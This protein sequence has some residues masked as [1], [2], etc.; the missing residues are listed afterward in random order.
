MKKSLVSVLV[1]VTSYGFGQEI[2][3]TCFDKDNN[4]VEKSKSEYCVV[5]KQIDIPVGVTEIAPR[6]IYVDTL[7]GFYTS[8]NA[9]KFIEVY[10]DEGLLH[11]PSI[12]YYP[13]RHVLPK[14]DEAER[15]S[16]SNF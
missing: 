14:C 13:D 3:T 12:E 16:K 10:N 15:P 11:G 8:T 9:L 7:K 1:L 2:V 6:K 4:K 5:G